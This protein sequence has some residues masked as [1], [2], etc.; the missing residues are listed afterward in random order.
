MT[1]ALKKVMSEYFFFYVWW[2]LECFPY[3]TL[4]V[5]THGTDNKCKTKISM[6]MDNPNSNPN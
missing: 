5:Q 3:N 1:K 4:V 2:Q 6:Q